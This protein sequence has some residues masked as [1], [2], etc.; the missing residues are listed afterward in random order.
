MAAVPEPR[1]KRAAPTYKHGSL[2]DTLL[3]EGRRLLEEIGPG[4]L[5][6]RE[7][8]RRAGVSEA[9]PS[10]YFG[11]KEGLLAGIASAGF[12]ELE[13]AR[14]A[15]LAKGLDAVE[16]VREMMYSYVGYARANRGVFNLMVGPRI[17][18]RTDHPELVQ[19]G[20]S[21]FNLFADAVVTLA[22]A[23]GWTPSQGQLVAHTAWAVEH[24]LANLILS[25]RA[26]QPGRGV[27]PEQ[28]VE[29][30]ITL[31]LRSI[32]M[33]PALLAPKQAPAKR[34]R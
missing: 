14:R 33:G 5:S 11:D 10:R 16:T 13:A 17:I 28:M 23:S 12:R 9:S 32:A 15:T 34:R 30:S 24:G 3:I 18:R 4:E 8:A 22:C 6:L 7:V 21:S 1:R 31:L 20:M 25:D 26:P 19:A 2:Y 27:D 29:F